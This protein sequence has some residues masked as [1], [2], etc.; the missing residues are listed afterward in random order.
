MDNEMT[1]AEIEQL[2]VDFIAAI[3]AEDQKEDGFWLIDE[4]TMDTVLECPK[5][6]GALRF[7][8]RESAL[9]FLN[10]DRECWR[11]PEPDDN[12]KNI[13]PFLSPT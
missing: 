1:D 4:G 5:C 7:D 12:N 10:D 2:E 8:G 13:T 6:N 9:F 11:C 3:N